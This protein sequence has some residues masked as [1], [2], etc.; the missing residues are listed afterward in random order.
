MSNRAPAAT[1]LFWGCLGLVGYTYL[2]APAL[3]GARAVV[4]PKPVR[5]GPV[6]PPV[7]LIVPAYNEAEV[8]AAKVANSLA[9]DY[10]AERLEV[11]VVSDGSDD[12][13]DEIVAGLEAPRV[14]LVRVPRSGKNFAL[15]AGIAAARGDVLI[16]TDADTM[17]LPDAVRHLMAPF[18]DAT[19]GGVSGDYRHSS[20]RRETAGQRAYWDFERLHKR[21]QSRSGTLTSAGGGLYALRRELTSPLPPGVNDDFS[22]SVAV[23]AARR[24]LV[25]APS[26]VGVGPVGTDLEAEFRRKVRSIG[27]GFLGVWRVR[28]CLDPRRFGFFALQLFSHKVLR[29]LMAVPIVLLAGTG[30]SLWRHGVLYRVVA[31]LAIALHLAGAAGFVLRNRP[32]GRAKPLALPAYFGMV[33]VA[34][35]LAVWSLVRGGG[36]DAWVPERALAPA[37]PVSGR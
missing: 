16:F 29:R 17:L 19:V 20:T 4:A 24:R 31:A 34:S 35:L 8:I 11:V 36:S 32:L 22:L 6:F 18:A 21:W 27:G 9:L 2:G 5:R 1:G 23:P 10:P 37:P 26:A 15:N 12:G 28:R 25:F 14:R 13:T 7:T 30:A 33:N 3:T